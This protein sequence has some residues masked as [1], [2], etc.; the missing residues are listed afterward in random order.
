MLEAKQFDKGTSS[1]IQRRACAHMST[2]HTNA[3]ATMTA[4]RYWITCWLKFDVSMFRM[5]GFRFTSEEVHI[6]VGAKG[7]HGLILESNTRSNILTQHDKITPAP[8]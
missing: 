1:G 5:C 6:F 8:D 2:V 4:S 3:S 7:V